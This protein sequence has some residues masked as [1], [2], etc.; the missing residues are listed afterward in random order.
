LLRC[1][2][3]RY[4]EVVDCAAAHE[5]LP[6]Q[7]QLPKLKSATVADVNPRDEANKCD[8][9]P[10]AIMKMEAPQAVLGVREA[11][12]ADSMAVGVAVAANKPDG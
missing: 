5:R 6:P 1:C 10:A 12:L 8:G 4:V 9:I 11:P 7:P 2:P 3:A